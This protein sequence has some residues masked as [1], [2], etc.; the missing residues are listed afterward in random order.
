M[1]PAGAEPVTAP[2]PPRREGGPYVRYLAMAA[3]A[4]ILIWLAMKGFRW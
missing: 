4:A 3:I 1:A 2:P